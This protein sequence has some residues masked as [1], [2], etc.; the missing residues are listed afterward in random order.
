[1]DDR[2]SIG[3]VIKLAPATQGSSWEYLWR[4]GPNLNISR[5]I[6]RVNKTDNGSSY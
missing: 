4:I 3:P 5:K 1:L 6:G 2:K